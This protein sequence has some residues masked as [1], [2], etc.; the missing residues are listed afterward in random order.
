LFF[1]AVTVPKNIKGL[2]LTDGTK[3]LIISTNVFQR[4][5]VWNTFRRFLGV[6]LGHLEQFGTLLEQQFFPIL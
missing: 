6:F 1:S 2:K 4:G 3:L 5:T